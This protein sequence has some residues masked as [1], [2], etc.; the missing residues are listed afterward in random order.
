MHFILLLI[1]TITLMNAYSIIAA[2]L[3]AIEVTSISSKS[4]RVI[5]LF[6]YAIA[7][8]FL[9]TCFVILSI[10]EIGSIAIDMK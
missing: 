10:A 8:F 3:S 4:S 5:S 1:R 9:K 6:H 2:V 7:H